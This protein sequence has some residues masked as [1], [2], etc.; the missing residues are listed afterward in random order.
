M[1]LNQGAGDRSPS[2]T[3]GSGDPEST[4]HLIE[5][6]RAGDQGALERLFATSQTAPTMGPRPAGEERSSR[7]VFLR[8]EPAFDGLRGDPRFAAVRR[9]LGLP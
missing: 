6:A 9:K 2:E 1:P 7:L 3:S 8:V 5:R 4:F